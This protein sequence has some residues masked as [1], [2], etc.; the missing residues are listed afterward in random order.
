MQEIV[1]GVLKRP[2][3]PLRT[4]EQSALGAALLAAVA[5]GFYPDLTTACRAVVAYGPLSSRAP[6]TSPTM[7][8]PTRFT[9]R[10]IRAYA[11]RCT[12]CANSQ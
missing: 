4:V 11:T 7:T 6:P 3:T 8:R 9:A 2:I 10:S 12:R 5:A 1:A